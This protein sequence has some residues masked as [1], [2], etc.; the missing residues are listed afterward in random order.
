MMMTLKELYLDDVAMTILLC[1]LLHSLAV[2]HG[3]LLSAG[4]P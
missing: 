4:V 2:R 3:R 1:A